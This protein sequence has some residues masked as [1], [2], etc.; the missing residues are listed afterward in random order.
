MTDLVH[1]DFWRSSASYRVRL[2]MNV[3]GLEPEVRHVDMFSMEHRAPDYLKIN[4]QSM[5]PSVEIDGRILTQSIAIIR[6]LDERFGN[7]DL[8][9]IG[10]DQRYRIDQLSAIITSDI[11]PVCNMAVMHKLGEW[12]GTTDYIPVWQKFFIS[13]GLQ[14]LEQQLEDTNWAVGDRPTLVE[15]CL[16][17]QWFNA[18]LWNVDL[19]EFPKL[20][21]IVENAEK[22]DEFKRARPDY[23]KSTLNI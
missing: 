22:L 20:N 7:G 19:S 17:P 13:K 1:Y 18:K 12:S 23:V 6:Y 5:L 14:A 21:R 8:S 11:A 16:I 15:C 9:G 10:A 2:A 3:L 4:P